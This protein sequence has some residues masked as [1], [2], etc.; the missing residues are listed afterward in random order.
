GCQEVRRG[1]SGVM[2]Y[3]EEHFVVS[4]GMYATVLLVELSAGD[5]LEG[6]VQEITGDYKAFVFMVLDPNGQNVFDTELE[7]KYDFVFKATI[8][9]YYKL[10]FA[11]LSSDKQVVVKYRRT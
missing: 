8:D 4:E 7:G 11:S 3:H 10:T 9:G 1:V 6:S 5:C 2:P